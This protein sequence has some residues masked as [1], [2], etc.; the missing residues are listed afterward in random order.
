MMKVYWVKKQLDQLK[1]YKA[2]PDCLLR[3]I[4]DDYIVVFTGNGANA[5]NQIVRLNDTAAFIFTQ[6]GEP[7]TSDDVLRAVEAEYEADARMA[8]DVI[9][10]TRKFLENDLIREE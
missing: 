5:M 10:Y 6:Y 3:K 2:N 9:E 7:K 1:V 8:Q 4:G